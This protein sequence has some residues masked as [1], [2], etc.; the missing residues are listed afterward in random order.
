M[1]DEVKNAAPVAVD[2][3][4]ATA[5]DANSAGAPVGSLRA[6]TPL[7][8]LPFTP[9]A[10]KFKVQT[11]WPKDEP[12]SALVVAYI[13]VR[14]V[15]ERLNAVCPDLW[16]AEYVP[17]PD[18]KFLICKLT[19]DGVTRADVGESHKG[20]SKDLWSDALKRAAV[21]FG[22][23]VS[24]YA[25]PQIT[26]KKDQPHL[27]RREVWDAKASKKKPTLVLT[28]IGHTKLR[29]GYSRW[30]D[31][32]AHRFG[33]APLDHGDVEG[34]VVDE[35]VEAPDDFVPELP[36]AVADD[37]GAGLIAKCRG[38]YDEIKAL[39]DGDGARHVTPGQFN[40]WLSG[41]QHSHAELEKL[42]AHL[43]VRRDQIAGQLDGGS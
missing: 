24:V 15:I 38:L 7:L 4:R 20:F 26:L 13:D 39:G 35:D 16:H 9:E 32:H 12:H 1:A 6:A 14:L 31:E 2:E 37:I 40:G 3:V 33:G 41:A 42:V 34:A 23:G 22:I 28:E 18:E 10:I 36:P 43:E 30:L 27:E 17:A 8:R 21:Q 5:R 29:E 11:V 25:L 19:I